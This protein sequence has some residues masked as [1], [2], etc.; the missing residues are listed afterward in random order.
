MARARFTPD[1]DPDCGDALLTSAR[2]DIVIGRWQGLRDLLR[3]TGADWLSR[4][5]RTRLL[6]QACAGST[7]VESWLAA[8]PHSADALVLHAATETVRAFTLAIAAGRG[9]PIDRGRIDAAV[10]ACLRATDA[11]PEDPT[12]WV[13]LISAARLYPAG[14]RRRELARWWDEL[15]RRDPYSV[16]GHLQVLHYYSARWHG[17]HGLMYDFARDA[18]GVAPPGCALPVLVQYA[19]VEEFRHA[20][21]SAKGQQAAVVLGQH[22]NHD[23]A[24]SDVR[25]T[26]HRWIAGRDDAVVAPAEL[27][28]LN[29]LAHAACHAGTTDIA[30][31]VL[32]MLGR[33]ATR[34]PWS[35]LGDPAGQL[36]RWHR[37][38]GLTRGDGQ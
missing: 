8:E 4:G 29:H 18:A 27:R 35:Y 37:D 20:L 36:T 31:A 28:D 21:D 6:A 23:G 24:V 12:P 9:V 32:R 11:W 38:L 34:T 15:H 16:E 13:S 17:S 33:R 14:V 5:H 3:A 19:R 22:W 7:T 26:W 25:R 30:S 1:F 10:L 2:H